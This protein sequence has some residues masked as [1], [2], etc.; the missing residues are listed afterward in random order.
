MVEHSPKFMEIY[1]S[2]HPG[3]SVNSKR[4][5]SKRFIPKHIITKLLK[6]KDSEP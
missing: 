6:I 2:T 5:N 4:V 3:G 1:L